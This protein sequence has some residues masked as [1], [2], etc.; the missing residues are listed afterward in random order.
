MSVT[1]F[2]EKLAASGAC[3]GMYRGAETPAD[4]GDCEAEFRALLEGC[5]LPTRAGRP[6]WCCRRG[7]RA[8][9]NGMVTNNVRD[10]GPG[11]G[12]YSFVLNAQGRIQVDLVAY[13]RGGLP[14]GHH[15]PRAS[16][17]SRRDF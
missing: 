1:T 11:H 5:A 17:E 9:P 7:P 4:F 13:N 2:Q 3:L 16:A 8:R 15:R 14:A 10:M 12:V 6:N